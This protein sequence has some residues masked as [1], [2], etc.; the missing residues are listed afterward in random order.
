MG[1]P[2]RAVIDAETAV[3]KH[4]P[5]RQKLIP[6]FRRPRPAHKPATPKVGACLFSRACDYAL[7]WTL[8]TYPGHTKGVLA[9][10]G[11]PITWSAVGHWKRGKRQPPEWA[12]RVMAEYIRRQCEVGLALATELEA[13]AVRA[14]Q[15]EERRRLHLPAGFGNRHPHIYA[16]R[17]AA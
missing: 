16:R 7:P 5:F 4:I 1:W 17:E 8:A 11:R 9:I 2:K 13:A 12:C 6:G 15:D 14:S 10:L 3:P